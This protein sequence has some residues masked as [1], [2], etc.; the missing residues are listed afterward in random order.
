MSFALG[1][2]I[3]LYITA[4]MLRYAWCSGFKDGYKKGLE[5]E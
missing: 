2:V 3:T 4:L 5:N 1:V